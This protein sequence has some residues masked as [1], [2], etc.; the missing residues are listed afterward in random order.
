MQV[1]SVVLARSIAFFDVGELNPSGRASLHNMIPMLKER[2]AFQFVPTKPEEFQQAEGIE[3]KSGFFEGQ[4][5]ANMTLY[6]DG[7]KVDLHSSTEEA[8][9]FLRKTLQW[10]ADNAGITYREGILR[11]WGFLSQLT[12]QSNVDLDLVNPA[13]QEVGHETSLVVNERTGLD[14][15]Y[16]TNQIFLN[17]DRAYKDPPVAPFSIERRAKQ[18][19]EDGKYFSSAPLQ[20]K[21]HIRILEKFESSLQASSEGRQRTIRR[22]IE[23]THEGRSRQAPGHKD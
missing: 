8:Q 5:I 17:F 9:V 20:T 7:I 13:L 14:V 23:A 2:F 4:L 15:Q 12:Y 22:A 19:F 3:F 18:P 11:R 1:L 10:L 21:D 6:N 16:R